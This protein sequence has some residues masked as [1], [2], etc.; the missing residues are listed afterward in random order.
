MKQ[1]IRYTGGSAGFT[2]TELLVVI[3]VI[4]IL[5]GF[6]YAAV[7]SSYDRAKKVNSQQFIR[8]IDGAMQMFNTDFGH[9]PYAALTGGN[10]TN[11][12]AWI[13]RWLTGLKDDGDP[14][15]TGVRDD[16]SWPGKPYI[17]PD[18]KMLDKDDNYLMTDAWGNLIYFEVVNPIFNIDR[19]DIWSLGLDGKGSTSMGA[20]STGTYS[21]RRTNYK[22]ATDNADN[23]GNW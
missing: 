3:A 18:P 17:E 8:Q 21:A 14:D 16:P 23:F 13:R 4:G 15:T 2:L 19:W 6:V 1:R 11:N 20:F 9:P 10:K 5:A 12:Q 22:N 7:S